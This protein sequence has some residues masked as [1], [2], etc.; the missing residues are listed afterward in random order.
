MTWSDPDET[1]E[2]RKG[3]LEARVRGAVLQIMVRKVSKDVIIKKRHNFLNQQS[4]IWVSPYPG[5]SFAEECLPVTLGESLRPPKEILHIYPLNSM[6]ICRGI[7]QNV[8]ID[9]GYGVLWPIHC[10]L[11]CALNVQLFKCIQLLIYVRIS[12]LRQL[13]LV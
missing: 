8:V 6:R 5:L 12:L 4:I 9:Y 7:L 11:Y 3:G 1:C 13:L 2:E 10:F